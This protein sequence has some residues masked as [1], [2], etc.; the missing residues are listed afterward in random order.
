MFKILYAIMWLGHALREVRGPVIRRPRVNEDDGWR[1][2]IPPW[3]HIQDYNTSLVTPSPWASVIGV[4]SRAGIASRGAW[5]PG[6][7]N[8]Y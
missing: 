8:H 7:Q 1:I 6:A 4:G 3:E 2:G 5:P